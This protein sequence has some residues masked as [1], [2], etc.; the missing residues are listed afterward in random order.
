[1]YGFS[2]TLRATRIPSSTSIS[3]REP[4]MSFITRGE[5]A[6]KSCKAIR[7]KRRLCAACDFQRP[8]EQGLAQMGQF[9]AMLMGKKVGKNVLTKVV[10]RPESSGLVI[11][12]LHWLCVET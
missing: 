8:A 9:V 11:H 12:G 4:H 7:Q 6:K 3:N 2:L 10:L 5:K 1:V